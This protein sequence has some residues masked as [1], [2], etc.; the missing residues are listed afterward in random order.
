MRKII[1]LILIIFIATPAVGQESQIY[2]D[3]GKKRGHS[4]TDGDITYHYDS[5][6]KE[7]GH[8]LDAGDQTI[9]YDK[10]GNVRG[11]SQK[12]DGITYH[13]RKGGSQRGYSLD[14]G[15]GAGQGTFDQQLGSGGPRGFYDPAEDE[16]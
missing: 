16:N 6:G 12:E 14:V 11:Y 5:R 2:D 3:R 9:D 4:V 8:S 10:R 1:V 15:G 7:I 13:M